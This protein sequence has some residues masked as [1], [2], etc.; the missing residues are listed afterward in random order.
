MKAFSCSAIPHVLMS[1]VRGCGLTKVVR[2]LSNS[3]FLPGILAVERER[4]DMRCSICISLLSKSERSAWSTKMGWAQGRARA[5]GRTDLKVA[6]IMKERGL[7]MKQQKVIGDVAG[8]NVGDCFNFRI[9]MYILGVHK[10]IRA[11][12]DY[13]L[14]KDSAFGVSVAISVVISTD[15][16]YS[17][18]MDMGETVVYTGQ[19]G[20][21]TSQRWNVF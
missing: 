3:L 12:I 19:G 10:Q 20:M 15:E 16:Y 9:Q 8:M 6:S 1:T 7:W 5:R 11:G 2:I 18:D 13:I 4:E 21:V 14:A 17:D